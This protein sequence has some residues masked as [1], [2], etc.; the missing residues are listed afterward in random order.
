MAKQSSLPGSA[1]PN[2]DRNPGD[3]THEAQ[4]ILGQVLN[5]GTRSLGLH[6]IYAV[7]AIIPIVVAFAGV[8]DDLAVVRAQTPAEVLRVVLIL[9]DLEL[10][11]PRHPLSELL[12][13][14]VALFTYVDVVRGVYGH[15]YRGQELPISCS[16]AT[17]L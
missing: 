7:L 4:E 15:S 3:S 9:V 16:L 11:H 13:A 1:T 6:E 12:D 17:P 14:V 8:S 5:L 2:R 10:C